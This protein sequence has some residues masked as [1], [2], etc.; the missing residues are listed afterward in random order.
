MSRVLPSLCLCLCLATLAT[1]CTPDRDTCDPA[2]LDNDP[3]N[4]GQCGVVCGETEQ[5]IQRACVEGACQVGA[6]ESC[7]S[8]DPNTIDVG[9]CVAG[10]RTCTTAGT[11]GMCVDEVVPQQ[12]VCGNGVDENCSGEADE[13]VDNDMDG[14]TTCDGDCADGNDLINPGAFESNGNTVDDDCDGVA[15]NALVACDMGILSNTSDAMDFARALDLCQTTTMSS[16]RW[17]VL[18]AKLSLADG[19]TVIP[20][21]MARAIRDG[22][23]TGSGVAPP[24]G[25]SLAVLSSGAAA[26]MGD[27]NPAFLPGTSQSHGQTSALP[28]DW[29]M[30]NGNMLPNTVGCPPPSGSNANDPAM[31]TVRMRVPSNAKSFSV[32]VNFMS[33]EYPEWSC[34]AFNDFFVALLDST[35]AGEPANPTDKNLAFYTNPTTMERTP[36]GVNLAYGN[37]GL[38]TECVNGPAG[39]GGTMFTHTAC[40]SQAFLP[41]TGFDVMDPFGS[42]CTAAPQVSGGGTGW[43]T[44]SGNVVGGEIITLRFAIWDTSDSAF[45]STVLIDDFQWS[46]E[47]AEPGTVIE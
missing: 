23:G 43:L 18:D 14:F 29:Y 40:T 11:W 28:Q 17:G 44:T 8:G 13:N 33:H 4:C 3:E 31:L 27:T 39:C 21:P 46:V 38:F 42:L 36:V 45:D 16:I 34:S 22:W 19:G 47:A 15:D 2:L 12:E 10:H 20:N 7:Y 9:T 35:F 1:A 30:A 37:T 32:K 25:G 6:T 5:C 26:D 41:G 24:R